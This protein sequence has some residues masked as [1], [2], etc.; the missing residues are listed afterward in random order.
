MLKKT[1]YLIALTLLFCGCEKKPTPETPKSPVQ[2]GVVRIENVPNFVKGVGQLIPAVEVSLRAQVTGTLT[3]VL[4]TD[5]QR[6]NE[7]DLLMTIDPRV[8]EAALQQAQGQ[9]QDNQARLRYA[10]EFANTY[11]KLVGNEYVSRLDYEQALQNVDVY[12]AGIEQ[13]RAAIKK[14]EVD[15]GYTQVRAPFR[16]YLGLRKYDPGNYVAATPDEIL[17]TLKKI[18]PLSV[19]FFLSSH[20]LADIQTYQK[21]A[22]LYLEAELPNMPENRLKGSLWFIDNNVD[23]NTGM[24]TL[25]GNLPNEDERGWPGQFVR[26][27]LRLNTLENAVLVPRQAVILGEQGYY[28][29]VLDEEKMQVTMRSITK[30]ITYKDSY[31]V[32]TGLKEG[33]KVVIDGQL[34]LVNN[35]A[36]YIPTDDKP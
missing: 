19:R 34:N 4:F 23:A 10:Q 6:V 1:N 36:V 14:A 16:G 28:V 29:F 11:G 15:L 22:P 20:Y 25:E 27:H 32:L 8:Y 24:I 35:T 21:E 12:K 13:A 31:V 18:T 30:G 33:E 9:L 17:V 5:G 26:V 2:V 3:S 7:G